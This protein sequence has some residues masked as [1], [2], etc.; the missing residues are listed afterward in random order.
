MLFR[1]QPAWAGVD[2]PPWLR[3]LEQEVQRVQTLRSDDALLSGG[4]VQVAQVQ[5][6]LEDVQRLI[7]D[8]VPSLEGS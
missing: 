6:S 5:L 3:R 8:W 4:F 2:L 1:S 7:Q